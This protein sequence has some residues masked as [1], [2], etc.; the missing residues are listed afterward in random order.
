MNIKWKDVKLNNEIVKQLT[1]KPATCKACV[2]ACLHPKCKK[3]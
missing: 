2:V 3:L 1:A